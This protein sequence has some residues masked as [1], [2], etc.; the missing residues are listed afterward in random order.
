MTVPSPEHF[1][2]TITMSP[3]HLHHSFRDYFVPGS[4]LLIAVLLLGCTGEAP[5]DGAVS[6]PAKAECL[7]LENVSIF[8]SAAGAV[9]AMVFSTSEG[10]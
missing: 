6:E 7:I 9:T 2:H 4:V 5:T 3:E 1:R 8:D 10:G